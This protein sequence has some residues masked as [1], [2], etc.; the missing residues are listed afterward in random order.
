MTATNNVVPYL[1]PAPPVEHGGLV[2]ATLG[3]AMKLADMMASAKL[4]PAA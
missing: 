2:P 4:V 3:E 1:P